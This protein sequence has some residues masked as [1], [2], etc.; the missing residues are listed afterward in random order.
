[1]ALLNSLRL[2]R[3]GVGR[4]PRYRPGTFAAD[5]PVD[6]NVA[7]ALGM[8]DAEGRTIVRDDQGRVA[9]ADREY[10]ANA[11]RF[12]LEPSAFFQAAGERFVN[13]P[14]VHLVTD[15]QGNEAVVGDDYIAQA[16]KWG[17]TG[18]EFFEGQRTDF[19]DTPG[20]HLVTDKEGGRALVGDDYI[21]Q[22]EQ[23]GLTGDQFFEGQRT[24]FADTRL[25]QEPP[26]AA[27]PSPAAAPAS[28]GQQEPQSGQDRRNAV[29][30]RAFQN[31]LHWHGD[32]A[33][34]ER[35]E[36]IVARAAEAWPQLYPDEPLTLDRLTRLVADR[37]GRRDGHAENLREG[38]NPIKVN[39]G[40]A[41]RSGRLGDDLRRL[42]DDYDETAMGKDVYRSYY[43]SSQPWL[44][45]E[46]PASA[47]PSP[48]AA[49][50][51]PGQQDPQ[52]GQ[53]NPSY[54]PS[55]SVSPAA[56]SP[57]PA[58]APASPGQQEPQSGQDR[59]NAVY[60]RAFQNH[61]H[62]HGDEAGSERFERIVARAAEA[63]PQLYPDEPLTLDRLTRLVA[64]RLGRRDGH[65]E[66]LREGINPIK[67]NVGLALR[68]GRLGDDL[69]RLADDYDETAMGKD[70]YRSYYAS[71]Q[72]WLH[73]E[74]PAAA[75]PS[76]AAGTPLA[77]PAAA[78]SRAAP[79]AAYSPQQWAHDESRGEWVYQP[80]QGE[81]TQR[82]PS[83]TPP[84]LV[85]GGQWI[86]HENRQSWTYREP[87]P[88]APANASSGQT[89]P[90]PAE[91]AP[92]S[93]P[94]EPDG[95]RP[96]WQQIMDSEELSDAQKQYALNRLRERGLAPGDPTPASAPGDLAQY[97]ESGE[98]PP[99]EWRSGWGGGELQQTRR[100][101]RNDDGTVT[102]VEDIGL[103][104]GRTTTWRI[105]DDGT[106]TRLSSNSWDDGDDD[107]GRGRSAPARAY[108]VAD[109]GTVSYAEG[110]NTYTV[111]DAD[112]AADVRAA[113]ETGDTT[114]LS[115]ASD[116][117]TVQDSAGATLATPEGPAASPE[118]AAQSPAASDGVAAWR[119][120]L[121]ARADE[122]GI[123]YDPQRPDFNRLHTEVDAAIAEH[124]ADIAESLGLPRD[125]TIEQI[126]AA[127]AA[128][129]AQYRTDSA[130]FLE[131]QGFDTSEMT[132][133][134]IAALLPSVSAAAD[135]QLG[136]AADALIVNTFDGDEGYGGTI[137][138]TDDNRAEIAQRVGD[139]ADRAQDRYVR[140]TLYSAID[141]DDFADD[142]ERV[143]VDLGL[144]ASSSYEEVT[145][146]IDQRNIAAALDADNR[147]DDLERI[148]V[149]LGMPASSS[150]EEVTR[151]I[152]QR[153]IAAVVDADDRADA[154]ERVAVDTGLAPGATAEQVAV[155]QASIHLAESVGLDKADGA[156]MES[157][158][159]DGTIR[160]TPDARL[161]QGN[162]GVENRAAVMDSLTPAQKRVYSRV[163]LQHEKPEAALFAAGAPGAV[164]AGI[165]LI[166][167]APALTRAGFTGA[168]T[169]GREFKG[170]PGMSQGH[171]L[172]W[173]Q[174]NL[175]A[176]R[177]GMAQGALRIPRIGA[178][179][180]SWARSVGDE[181]AEQIWFDGAF[182]GNVPNPTDP[183]D[184][185]FF[186][187]EV[188]VDR[189]AGTVRSSPWPQQ[190][191]VAPEDAG[192]P[193]TT[194]WRF[195]PRNP[196]AVLTTADNPTQPGQPSPVQRAEYRRKVSR[197]VAEGVPRDIAQRMVGREIMPRPPAVAGGIGRVPIS[198][199]TPQQVADF[200]SL[201]AM[202]LNES[203][204]AER[205]GISLDEPP[206]AYD[207]GLWTPPAPSS[208]ATPEQMADYE[209][210]VAMG[211]N[212]ATA[213]Q[214][215]GISAEAAEAPRMEVAAAP[216]SRSRPAVQ[217]A[218]AEPA[219]DLFANVIVAPEPSPEPAPDLFANVLPAPQP[220]ATPAR[221]PNRRVRTRPTPT[222]QRQIKR[223][224]AKARLAA[225]AAQRRQLELQRE[226]Q[227][228]KNQRMMERLQQAAPA[229]APSPSPTP[230]P[231][232]G[233]GSQ[234]SESRTLSSSSSSAPQAATVA[235]PQP[236]R[237]PGSEPSPIPDVTAEPS[238][239]QPAP[240]P[241]T[242]PTSEPVPDT[243]PTPTA[244]PE[245]E[246]ERMAMPAPEPAPE[247]ASAAA[248]EPLTEPASAP[249]PE[250]TPDVE[251]EPHPD[252][253]PEPEP[254]PEPS[255]APEPE[256]A[257]Q[258]QSV[259]ELEPTPEFE[260]TPEPEPTPETTPPRQPTPTPTTPPDI[261][262]PPGTPP[263]PPGTT[264]PPG[265]PPPPPETT[266][267]VTPAP[268][269]EKPPKLEGSQPVRI[270]HPAPAKYPDLFTWESHNLHTYDPQTRLHTS[271]RLSN[272]NLETLQAVG[273]TKHR[274][275]AD[276]AKVGNLELI[277]DADG[278]TV[279]AIEERTVRL[280]G[281]LDR[282]GRREKKDSG[283]QANRNAGKG[284]TAKARKRA[285]DKAQAKSPAGSRARSRRYDDRGAGQYAALPNGSR[286]GRN[287]RPGGGRK[288]H[289]SRPEEEEPNTAAAQLPVLLLGK[290]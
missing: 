10:V 250:P 204:A 120:D 220:E 248:L 77:M 273:R 69:R 113:A 267:P 52:S 173:S 32:E 252:P 271:T 170:A 165:A 18:D 36:R 12:G 29:Y 199:A 175:S 34:S 61:L 234:P 186:G 203:L 251:L 147:A 155:R 159:L 47:S 146:T 263:P 132:D 97:L 216:A 124:N 229:P 171:L 196:D 253:F 190:T 103:D 4:Q 28:P 200:E 143:A 167:H 244:Q 55:S 89:A 46:P 236:V 23:W 134:E 37:L 85:A 215:A 254:T 58:A 15:T 83:A 13:T 249:A 247:I 96:L 198:Q 8:P 39:V 5:T 38:I 261:T 151:T 90:P 74:P 213:A 66:N 105:N 282:D 172:R 22:A 276:E 169:V 59:R 286:G 135:R 269:P 218:V 241:Q 80:A 125:A 227:R 259:P 268:P 262:P 25:H 270:A 260:P 87:Q 126:Q 257:P 228:A 30:A 156:T 166:R 192:M 144:P 255:P 145:R 122:L 205:A 183:Y 111:R 280:P 100:F 48:A 240:V 7:R 239:A 26:A 95:E 57:S 33:G 160:V 225:R 279:N 289:R 86:F 284:L 75:S 287:S 63:W 223:R 185:A 44:H 88:Q 242:T 235:R 41:L 102:L 108:T 56:A 141:A 17:L 60:A 40:L 226:A 24:D 139:A 202:G 230:Q 110:D 67:V 104:E 211:V 50:A 71:S 266:P 162:A 14:G 64:D 73:R 136:R 152:D 150:Y 81:S 265:T 11:Q 117:V 194:A 148:A 16:E 168:K 93:A 246:P 79:D 290:E 210:L 123:G 274:P 35:F 133:E 208:Q 137:T 115:G 182:T 206:Q 82:P 180:R 54:Y 53:D 184:L 78:P 272:R 3:R 72:P 138:V 20:V 129:Q 285:A 277:S 264:P 281:N 140:R 119:T 62:W 187:G 31:H 231:A 131:T 233:T 158:L 164:K 177:P 94:A 51:S 154:L 6:A 207:R 179:P 157:L 106:V 121:L 114:G 214:R 221:D 197:L 65:A 107:A 101:R 288:G 237:T 149:D 224:E 176:G 70:V 21:A 1:M 161:V 188:L 243:E 232:P 116:D 278:V 222:E 258:Q 283:G 163:L 42:A 191:N 256:P 91:P 92:A 84:D 219:P 45:R 195:D 43:A 181:A 118:P 193:G 76:P 217:V 112:L 27:S 178:R 9:L 174:S 127:S 109:D 98:Q 238:P 212:P 189:L 275:S 142:Q 99:R 130:R 49:P 209:S 68:S 153:N 128:A 19:A 245:P 201:K 2:H